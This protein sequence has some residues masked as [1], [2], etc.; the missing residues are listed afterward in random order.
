M[1]DR[2]AN[3]HKAGPETATCHAV[4]VNVFETGVL[5]L[6]ESGIGKSECALDLVSRGHRLVADDAVQIENAE[7]V[8]VGEAPDLT[9]N[10]LEIR[11]LGIINVRDIF[12]EAAIYERSKIDLC[13]E[14]RQVSAGDRLGNST[15][16]FE[17]C[18]AA[19]PK[20]VLPVSTGRNIAT[21]VE[22]AVRLYRSDS[23]GNAVELLLEKHARLMSPVP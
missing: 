11:G 21:L 17:I 3:E 12:G 22:T 5:L 18:G 19:V 16:E 1:Q 14:L 10:L 7:N 8:L 15:S 9:R 23:A 13:V 2:S 20:F 4:L 6:G